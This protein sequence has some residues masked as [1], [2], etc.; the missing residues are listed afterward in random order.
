[1]GLAAEREFLSCDWGTSHFRLKWVAQGTV[2]AEFQDDNGC[3]KLYQAIKQNTSAGRAPLFEQQ[4]QFALTQIV[5]AQAKKPVPL[6]ISGMVSS[7]IGWMEL[8]YAGVPM[9]LDGSGLKTEFVRWKAPAWIASTYLISGVATGTNMM[10]GE[11]TEAIGLLRSVANLPAELVLLLPGTHSKHLRISNGVLRDVRTYM[12]GELYAVL[13]QH[14]VLAAS[15]TTN[16]SISVEGFLA[17]VDGAVRDGFAASL[18]QTRTRQVLGRRPAEENAAF[19]SGLLVGSE[20]KDLTQ[21][22]GTSILL[23]GASSLRDLY[24][25]ALQHLGI[26]NWRAFSD[27]ECDNAVPRGHEIILGHLQ[28]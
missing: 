20:L 6:L 5:K 15:L 10:R 28:A 26:Q 1:M 22:E 2:V 19:L 16:S 9:A 25:R 23:G 14:S 11:E 18:F 8:P 7:T 24:G 27:A 3:K 4:L 12:T 17:G 21:A 13:S